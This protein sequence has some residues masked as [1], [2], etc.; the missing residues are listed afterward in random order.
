MAAVALL[1]PQDIEIPPIDAPL[2]PQLL[3]R[4]YDKYDE[5]ER[6]VGRHVTLT[7]AL[8]IIWFAVYVGAAAGC[9]QL[10][11]S[12]AWIVPDVPRLVRVGQIVCVV[13]A[14]YTLHVDF[15]CTNMPLKEEPELYA[16]VQGPMGKWIFLTRQVVGFQAVH[17]VIT[18]I[19]WSAEWTTILRGSY[20]LA[21]YLAGCG[22]FV[23]IQFF[24]LV[25][26]HPD[27]KMSCRTWAL[28][29]MYSRKILRGLHV[30]QVILALA[31]M[32][33][34]RSREA[35]VTAMPSSVGLLVGFLMYVS[36]Y[37]TLIH[38]NHALTDNWPYGLMKDLGN[39]VA[40]W[41]QFFVIQTS[42]LLVFAF[43]IWTVALLTPGIW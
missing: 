34:L 35:L 28:R 20:Y 27:F 13:L 5:E 3:W 18:S 33:L 1:D 2:W 7:N 17:F 23:T 42:I 15:F 38:A 12:D 43:S 40:K 25:D 29:G 32:L 9:A 16:V 10:N 24:L 36:F 41:A 26:Q 6:A 30:P 4:R 8:V 14:L 21:P 22:A 31:D 19:A 39:S 37:F 11:D